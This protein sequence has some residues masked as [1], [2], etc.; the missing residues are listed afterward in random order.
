V[1][2][3]VQPKRPFAFSYSRMKNFE[4]CPRRHHEVDLKK[5]FRESESEQ[6]TWGN[7]V[8]KGL[9]NRIAKGVKLPIGMEMY[10]ELCQKIASS[11]GKV[12]T[13]QQLAINKDFGP[14]AWFAPDAWFR[15]KIDVAI[16]LEPV[17]LVVDF[18]TGKIVEDSVQLTL[19]AAAMFAHAP[20]VKKIRSRFYW[21]GYA[22]EPSDVDLMR[23]GMPAFWTSIWPRVEALKVA[24][25]TDNY[26][27]V[28]GRLCRKWCPVKNCEYW[29]K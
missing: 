27:P 9:E 26:P 2:I 23:D 13:E 12:L 21:L 20:E 28:P 16:V 25:D 29:G 5:S 10:E 11:P 7:A 8:H 17:A 6:L 15:A 22:A 19:S 4:V 18:K 24:Y 14:T 1:N 3:A